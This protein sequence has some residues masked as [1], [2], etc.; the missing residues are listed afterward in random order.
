MESLGAVE[1]TMES[2]ESIFL[3]ENPGTLQL[4]LWSRTKSATSKKEVEAKVRLPDVLVWVEGF[5][6]AKS[7]STW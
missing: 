1:T 2:A 5:T 4:L 6:K 7:M 3:P